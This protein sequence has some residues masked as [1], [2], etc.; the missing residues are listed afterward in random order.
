MAEASEMPFVYLG[1]ARSEISRRQSRA[2]DIQ[3]VQTHPEK[4]LG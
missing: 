1:C 2:R 3:G 4:T